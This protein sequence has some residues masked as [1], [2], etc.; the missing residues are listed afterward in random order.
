MLTSSMDGMVVL[1]SMQSLEPIYKAKVG[2]APPH[3]LPPL[4]VILPSRSLTG[5]PLGADAGSGGAR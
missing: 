5:A 1:W 4:W 3:A 2:S